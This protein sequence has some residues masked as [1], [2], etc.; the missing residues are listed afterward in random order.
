MNERKLSELE[1]KGEAQV[2]RELATG[3]HGDPGSQAWIDVDTW[4]RLKDIERREKIAASDEELQRIAA[5]SAS[6]SAT[7]QAK[8]NSLM[9][10][11]I[12][13]NVITAILVAIISTLLAK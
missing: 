5:S 2:L 6:R 1:A 10:I 7:E 11:M 13:V 4:L 9:R 3:L 8:S 12:V